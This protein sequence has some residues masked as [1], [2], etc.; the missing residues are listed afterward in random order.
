MER[1]LVLVWYIGGIN[2]MIML[3]F[4]FGGFGLVNLNSLDISLNVW[5]EK[6]EIYWRFVWKRNFRILGNSFKV[7]NFLCYFKVLGE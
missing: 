5:R 7:R 2:F 6:C 1:G 3:L 4:I